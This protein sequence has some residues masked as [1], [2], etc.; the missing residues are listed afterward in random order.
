MRACIQPALRC[1]QHRALAQGRANQ[2]SYPA[3]HVFEH[4]CLLRDVQPSLSSFRSMWTNARGSA[5]QH[6]HT[7]QAPGTSAPSSVRPCSHHPAT[8]SRDTAIP[9]PSS[10]RG[11]SQAARKRRWHSRCQAL[12]DPGAPGCTQGPAASTSASPSSPDRQFDPPGRPAYLLFA[13]SM[14]L[15]DD[16]GFDPGDAVHLV[17]KCAPPLCTP[18]RM[19][20]YCTQLSLVSS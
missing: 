2:R 20:P 17:S 15:R 10:A 7:R 14:R 6:R 16:L 19:S 13:F 5:G 11:G 12:G 4:K 18:L 9:A 3:A 1:A 8:H